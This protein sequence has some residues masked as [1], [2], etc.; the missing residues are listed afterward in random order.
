MHTYFTKNG[1]CVD[2]R[3]N[4]QLECQYTYIQGLDSCVLGR[5]NE[6]AA[7]I[8]SYGFCLAPPIGYFC[9]M[10]QLKSMHDKPVYVQT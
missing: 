5:L 2:R 9:R 7:Q 6:K 10:A 3:W 8:L 4:R 1:S